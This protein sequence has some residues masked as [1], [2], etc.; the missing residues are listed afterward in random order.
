MRLWRAQGKRAV[1][2]CG[3]VCGGVRGARWRTMSLVNDGIGPRH[4]LEL[5]AVGEDRLVRREHHRARA[6]VTQQPLS[7]LGALGCRPGVHEDLERRAEAPQLVGPAG[8]SRE[9]RSDEAGAEGLAGRRRV[10]VQTRE[11][12]DGLQRLAEAHCGASTGVCA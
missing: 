5:G 1:I 12:R 4:A 10:A 3:G 8:E 2:A 9:G 6:A 7:H 11:H